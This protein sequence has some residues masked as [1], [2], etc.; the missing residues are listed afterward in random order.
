MPYLA[1]PL[2][3]MSGAAVTFGAVALVGAALVHGAL[4]Q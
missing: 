2:L 4:R 1:F 3:M